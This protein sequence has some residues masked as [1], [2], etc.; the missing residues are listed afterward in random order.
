V[1]QRTRPR[2]PASDARNGARGGRTIV[3]MRSPPAYVLGSDDAEVA[4][5]DAQAASI[6]PATALLLQAGGIGPEMRV[7]DLG[8]GLGHVAFAL[9]ELVG[10]DGA[11]VAI[12]LSAPLL[13]HAER[14]RAAAGLEHVRFVE[15]DVRSYRSAEPFDAVVG[16]LVL[17]HLPD[18]VDVVRHHAE[19]LRPG[20]R[21]VALDYDLG[22]VRGEPPLALLA[23]ALG[24]V[25]AA[26]RA[27]GADPRIGPRLARILAQAGLADTES[28]GLQS[29]YDPH[30]PTAARL[31]T[32]V[33]RTLSGPIVAAGIATAE[34]IGID[35]L[36]ERLAEE[37]IAMDATLLLPAVVGAWGIRR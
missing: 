36:E 29:Y 28:L 6:A 30:D 24:W 2:H 12:D 16:R 34:E 13:E 35:T 22:T 33:V 19:A 5:L 27:A 1:A 18:A 21:F 23:Q 17:F 15:A 20:G 7:L 9:A 3:E 26:F 4:R 25:E 14:R 37:G 10:R 32:A 31:L 8:T 11:V